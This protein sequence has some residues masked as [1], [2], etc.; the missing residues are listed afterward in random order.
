MFVLSCGLCYLLG[1]CVGQTNIVCF[2]L[3]MEVQFPCI[4]AIVIKASKM[5]VGNLFIVTYTGGTIGRWEKWM[6]VLYLVNDYT[7]YRE[8][9]NKSTVNGKLKINH[10]QFCALQQH[11]CTLHY[12]T[13]ALNF[14]FS[15]HVYDSSRIL[16]K[17][18][19]S[20]FKRSCLGV[21]IAGYYHGEVSLCWF[22]FVK[23]HWLS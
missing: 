2:G 9:R 16:S 15:E 5:K 22:L 10:S 13:N 21:E 4:R 17:F 11:T 20:M 6:T 12:S 3:V 23:V 7:L 19:F 14:S 1:F 8:F 18:H